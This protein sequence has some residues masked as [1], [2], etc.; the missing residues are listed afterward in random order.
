MKAKLCACAE[1]RVL[2]Q[3]APACPSVNPSVTPCL[4]TLGPAYHELG[5]NEHPATTNIFF[6]AS[7]SLT[8][9]LKSS[10]TTSTLLRR[11][12]FFDIKIVNSIKICL[13]RQFLVHLGTRYKVDPLNESFGLRSSVRFCQF[14]K[15]IKHISSYFF[16]QD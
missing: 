5:Y 13:L 12:D 11:A 9:I 8:V 3:S 2:W 1:S 10:V 16:L 14:F 15:G 7:K 6:L 4:N